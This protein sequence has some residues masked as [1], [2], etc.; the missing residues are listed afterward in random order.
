REL[1]PQDEQVEAAL[2]DLL[3]FTGDHRGTANLLLARAARASDTPARVAALK[4]AA[5]QLISADAIGE[6][7]QV[8]VQLRG[9]VAGDGDLAVALTDRLLER[10]RFGDARLLLEVVADGQSDTP[11][12]ARAR[13]LVRLARAARGQGDGDSALGFMLGARETDKANRSI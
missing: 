3:T 13:L 8:L 6:A 2:T 1:R 12:V 7:A 11:A 9:V 10:G 5:E 4:R